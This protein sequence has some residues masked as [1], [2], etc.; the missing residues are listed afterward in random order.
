MNS[1]FDYVEGSATAEYRKAVDQAASIAEQQKRKVDPIHH[2]KID[3]LLDTYAR[4]LAENTNK[5]NAIATRVPSILVAG[6][7]NFPVRKKEKT[8][9]GG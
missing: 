7:G 8:E 5:R 6:G 1:Y 3:Q 4:K 9:P 2:E